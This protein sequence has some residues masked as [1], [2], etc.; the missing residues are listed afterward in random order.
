MNSKNKQQLTEDE[1]E[2]YEFEQALKKLPIIHALPEEDWNCPE[3]DE[4]WI[5]WQKRKHK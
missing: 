2:D 3:D 4:Y 1:Q 5:E